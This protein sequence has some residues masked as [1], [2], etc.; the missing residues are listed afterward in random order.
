ME[1]KYLA[2]VQIGHYGPAMLPIKPGFK[3]NLAGVPATDQQLS[4]D[5][6]ANSTTGNRPAKAAARCW[7]CDQVGHFKGDP[8]CPGPKT[9]VKTGATPSAHGLSDADSLVISGEI[10]TE[11]AKF[12]TGTEIPDGHEIKR[13]GVVVAIWCSKC[14]RFLKG[15]SMHTALTHGK[16]SDGK[17]VTFAAPAPAPPPAPA[18]AAAAAAFLE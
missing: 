9:G 17:S 7:D 6:G 2:L 5:R 13:N 15:K 3:A 11:K 14:K 1:N 10:V 12:P 4:Q 8:K 16:K 18:T